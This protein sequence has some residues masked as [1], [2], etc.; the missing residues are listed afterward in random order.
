MG[1]RGGKGNR[2]ELLVS[3]EGIMEHK[4]MDF[5]C[6]LTT[7]FA[8]WSLLMTS[9]V[10]ECWDN[11]EGSIP[12]GV[13]CLWIC[14]GVLA[15]CSAPK[16]AKLGSLG[17]SRGSK[18]D[19]VPLKSRGTGLWRRWHRGHCVSTSLSGSVESKEAQCLSGGCFKWEQKKFV[20]YS[21]TRS[22]GLF[23]KHLHLCVWA[24][25]KAVR[26]KEEIPNHSAE[27]FC[28]RCGDYKRDSFP[29]TY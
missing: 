18:W 26:C 24:Q 4:R 29:P 20:G 7:H 5:I 6:C 22:A 12:D 14:T 11:T 21:F 3:L 10:W 8:L 1:G 2:K 28:W 9:R 16:W 25:S 15:G 23:Q 27:Q 13:H 17:C 19:W